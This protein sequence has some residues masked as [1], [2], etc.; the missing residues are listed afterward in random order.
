MILDCHV[1][2]GSC[3]S[4]GVFAHVKSWLTVLI[5]KGKTRKNMT[6]DIYTRSEINQQS[7][8]REQ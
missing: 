6:N 8:K 4:I 5:R 2:L 3:Q 1:H 7:N